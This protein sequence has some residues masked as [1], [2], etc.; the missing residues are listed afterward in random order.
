MRRL[1]RHAAALLLAAGVLAPSGV[2]AETL[3]VG[4]AVAKSFSFAMIDLGIKAGIFGKHGLDLQVTSFGGG[5]RLQQAMVAQSIDIGFGG[6]VDMAFVAKGSPITGVAAIAGPPDLIL[7]V[8]PDAG[9]DRLA[10]LKGK[11]VSVSSPAAVT[12]W[13]M[14]ELSRQQGWDPERQDGVTLVANAPQAGWAAMRTKEID[15]IYDF[16]MSIFSD[17]GRFKPKALDAI[18]RSFVDLKILEKE[19]DMAKLYTEALLPTR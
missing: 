16:Q 9:I 8:R 13:M 1:V 19:P 11:K 17:D 5:A 2:S 6:G 7:A 15:G 12:G 10:D 18:R 14:R 3:R 4:K